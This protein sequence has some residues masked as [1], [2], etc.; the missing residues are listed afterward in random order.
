MLKALNAFKTGMTNAGIAIPGNSLF[1]GT[2][3]GTVGAGMAVYSLG[4]W[5]QSPGNSKNNRGGA[6]DPYNTNNFKQSG[7][8]RRQGMVMSTGLFNSGTGPLPA[9]SGIWGTTKHYGFAARHAATGM[10]DAMLQYG[11]GRARDFLESSQ[12]LR[13]PITAGAAAGAGLGLVTGM[14]ASIF[15]KVPVTKTVPWLTALGAL[16]GGYNARK[17]GLQISESFNVAKKNSINRRRLST[18]AR[19]QGPGYRVWANASRKGRPG[20]LGA[21]GTLPF[22]MH[23]ARHRSTV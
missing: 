6:R 1:W 13:K 5:L 20:H 15:S 22:A 4:G 19:A 3:V 7:F 12:R 23:K 14:A 21:D 18:K 2:G 17:V 9:A 11:E 16:A 8:A 10:K